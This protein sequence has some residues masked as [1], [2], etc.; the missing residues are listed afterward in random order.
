VRDPLHASCTVRPAA[1]RR[2]R[3]KGKKE[4]KKKKRENLDS[5]EAALVAQ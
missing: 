3:K 1:T 4:R 5:I 2:N